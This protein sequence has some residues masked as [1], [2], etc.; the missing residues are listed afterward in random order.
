MSSRREV[1]AF[2]I[3]FLDLLSGAL[4]AVIILFVAVPKGGQEVR[5]K[6]PITVEKKL[7]EKNAALQAQ[8]NALKAELKK[9]E[10][11]I[12]IKAQTPIEAPPVKKEVVTEAVQTKGIL[13]VDV[14]F[15]FKGK[16]IVFLID[17]SG[18]MK[19]LDKMGQ[20]KAGLKM[21]ITSMPSDYQIDV[22]HFPGKRGA[23][24][25][26]L[27][28]YTQKLGERQKKD[29]YRFLNR[30]NPKGATPTRSALKYALTKYPDLTDVVLL[31]DGAPTKMN[32]S[33]YDDIKDI[34]SEVKKDN[35]KNIQIN[36]IGVGAAFS[37]QSTTPASVFLKELAKQSGGF[38]YGF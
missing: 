31:S 37:L 12:P 2:N 15:K 28:S 3:S 20:V 35:F 30:L 18:S 9:N 32:S 17:V 34:L 24:Y 19:T 5:K 36:T 7:K 38:F 1:N 8:V 13:D 11:K 14:G 23:R 33:E 25:Y 10:V 22:I 21:L 26:S 4:G 6:E 29:V 16:N 27:W